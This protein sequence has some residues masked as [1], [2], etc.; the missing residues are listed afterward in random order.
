MYPPEW[1]RWDIRP[2]EIRWPKWFTQWPNGARVA[3]HLSVMHEWESEPRNWTPAFGRP[4]PPNAA[5]KTDFLTL[6]YKE[7]GFTSGVWRIID[8]LD[9]QQVKVTVF[10]NGTAAEVWPD[11]IRELKNRGHEIGSHA[12]DQAVQ[13]V[14]YKTREEERDAMRQSIKAIEKAAGERPYAYMSP[15]PRPTMYTLELCAEEGFIWCS[16]FM[17]ADI[18]YVVN[19]AG[20]KLVVLCYTR[21]GY[22][23]TSIFG[24]KGPFRSSSE[25]LTS[26]KDEFDAVY[27][28][29]AIHPMRFHYSV[30]TYCTGMPGPAKTLEEF[31]KYVKGHTGVWIAT[32]EE[33]AKF[34][35]EHSG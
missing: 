33:Q 15:G 6:G 7:Y 16:E 17:N 23:D 14:I 34:W 8:L 27:E 9:R 20:K 11:G 3:V 35:L 29:S 13:P 21:P 30:H 5:Q 31:I 22:M 25:A 19:V 2:R 32:G 4:L 26:L 12:Y 10:T 18:P 28:E 24:T 1:F